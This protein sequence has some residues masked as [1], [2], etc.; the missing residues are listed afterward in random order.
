MSAILKLIS[1][2]LACLLSTF[3]VHAQN[4]NAI[5]EL[6]FSKD[7][8]GNPAMESQLWYA[9]KGKVS[10]IVDGQTIV[11]VMAGA[12]QSLLVHLAGIGSERHGPFSKSAKDRLGKVLLKKYVEFW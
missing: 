7:P 10:K 3:A 1:G 5:P 9:I 4:S 11:L 6:D 8:C 12:T 2:V